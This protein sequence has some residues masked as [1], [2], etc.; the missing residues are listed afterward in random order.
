MLG[1]DKPVK[2]VLAVV[3]VAAACNGTFG[4][5]RVGLE[6]D[7]IDDDGVAYDNCR[8]V[9]NPDQ[10]DADG[11]GL[12]D[13]CDPCVGADTQLF[14]D[15]D[16]D[17]IDDGCDACPIGANHDEDG[18][19]LFDA[20]DNCP[21]DVNAVQEDG[22]GDKVGDVCD[23]YATLVNEPVFFD[24]F[25]P[26]DIRW[27]SP[28]KPWIPEG[29][30]LLSPLSPPNPD[31]TSTDV[32]FSPEIPV[33]AGDYWYLDVAVQPI[34][35][36]VKAYI[37]FDLS[38]SGVRRECGVECKT[39]SCDVVIKPADMSVSPPA[40]PVARAGQV[41]R[42]RASA[43]GTRFAGTRFRCEI[44]GE[45]QTATSSDQTSN[46]IG[47]TLHTKGAARFTHVRAIR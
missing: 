11:D 20:C 12:G 8:T 30:A 15:D 39:T 4:L 14:L 38:A 36:E 6:P 41:L 5:D 32:I 9:S 35:D 46:H 22:D 10:L 19:G 2:A 1:Y 43:T 3:V 44:V 34:D 18:D 33:L 16:H 7:D 27:F 29:D 26:P 42:L 47:F 24:A 25:A 45:P 40:G 37:N 21:A 17:G 23:L 28:D 31:T 13:A